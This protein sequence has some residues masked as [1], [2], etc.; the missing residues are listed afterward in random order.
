M[1]TNEQQQYRLAFTRF[2][3]RRELLW[4]GKI[5]KAIEQQVKQF[6][7]EYYFTRSTY[8]LNAI[9]PQ[10]LVEVLRLLYADCAKWG[11]VVYN[12]LT[13][14]AT[15][16]A[17]MPIG[18]SEAFISEI[19][20]YFNV[21]LLNDVQNIDNTTR[22]NILEALKIATEKGLSI[23]DTIKLITDTAITYN[24]AR[25]IART[26]TVTAA[27]MAA[28]MAADKTGLLLTKTWISANDSRTRKD[29]VHVNGITIDKAEAFIVGGFKMMQP[30]DR[31]TAAMRTPA[32]EI[33]NC[34]CTVGFEAKRDNTGRIIYAS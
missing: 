21:D 7:D 34:R 15:R 24:R 30:G 22:N 2:Q 1:T 23:D 19:L 28:S 31:G 12:N 20:R 10:P 33:V 27:N 14:K 13:K 9:Q 32:K 11:N 8:S 17:R 29:H 25:V 26:E 3:K 4:T 16:K 18:M 5:K 6:T